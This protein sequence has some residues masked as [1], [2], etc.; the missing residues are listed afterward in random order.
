MI[1][2]ILHSVECDQTKNH[3]G[4]ESKIKRNILIHMFLGAKQH[5]FESIPFALASFNV[6][7]TW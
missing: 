7:F 2:S 1:R 4:H 3:K 5:N 6:W